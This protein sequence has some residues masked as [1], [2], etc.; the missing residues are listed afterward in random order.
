MCKDHSK[1]CREYDQ[2]SRRRFLGLS[3]GVLAASLVPAWLPRL[4][5][6]ESQNSDRDVLISIFLRGGCDSL[7]LCVPFL[8]PNYYRLR[9]NINIAPP[10]SSA[11]GKAID[12][13]GQ[14]GLAPTMAPLIEPFHDGAL[15][16]VHACG[17]HNPTRSHFSAMYSMEVGQI[18]PPADL[19]T[20]WLGRHLQITTPAHPQALLRA[21]GLT[22]G[23]PRTLVG[24]PLT[25]PIPEL[26]TFGFAGGRS[27]S[28]A[29]HRQ[30]LTGMYE[31]A[32]DL[33]RQNAQNALGTIDLLE[34]IDFS[35][36]APTGNAV[37]PETDFGSSMRSTAALIKAE[38]GVEAVAIDI[39]GWD[40]HEFQ[41]AV[42]GEM[43]QLMGDLAAGLAAF[44]R[45][46]WS[47]GMT[48]VSVVV[49]SEFGRNAF[50]NASLGCDHGHG[51]MMLVLGG[52][53]AGGRVVSEW[54]GLED[55]QLYEGQ[56]LAVTIDYRDV[57]S[58]ILSKRLDNPDI[59]SVFVDETYQPV[60][61]GIIA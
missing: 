53:V 47:G 39:D 21:V 13:D 30:A 17:T 58:E 55:E 60:D 37:Y 41:G 6:A 7:N 28:E 9:P 31:Y 52:G 16:V 19:F 51:T 8:E 23:L 44:Y 38:V 48:R 14:F 42:E 18:S 59:A 46:L 5:L 1:G 43:G 54:P 25:L 57:L 27:G 4:T 36:Y 49:M 26:D 61:R 50:E 34:T 2:L 15:A 40:T 33:L 32:D 3:G 56:D 10:D 20:G 29:E 22:D 12:L 35:G 45:D 11:A 24:G